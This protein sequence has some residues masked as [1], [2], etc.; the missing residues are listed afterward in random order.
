MSQLAKQ[1]L[2]GIQSPT[3]ESQTSRLNESNE[4]K[5][6]EL[7]KV[8]R[9]QDV[10]LLDYQRS[11][12]QVWVTI[13]LTI[14][15]ATVVAIRDFRSEGVLVLVLAGPFANLCLCLVAHALYFRSAKR[16]LENITVLAK[17]ESLLALTT[18]PDHA[19]V[20]RED[21]S[22]IPPEWVSS[23]D[24]HCTSSQFVEHCLHTRHRPI[25]V[26]F[27]VF[28]LI[29]LIIGAA[30]LA[31]AD[32]PAVYKLIIATSEKGTSEGALVYSGLVCFVWILLWLVGWP[33]L[34]K[35]QERLPRRTTDGI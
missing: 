30:V 22:I 6:L 24:A 16:H 11:S 2:E 33:V 4:R 18:R 7:Y 3:T 12:F 1:D 5:Y 27:F 29:N 34:S 17:L 13:L 25:S 35:E 28:Y 20:F 19:K 21:V 32:L 14:I 15:G 26:A 8:F 9:E 10:K 31:F 23:W